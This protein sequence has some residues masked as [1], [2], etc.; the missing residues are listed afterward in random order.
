MNLQTLLYP[1]LFLLL[2]AP[3]CRETSA[4]KEYSGGSATSFDFSLNAFGRISANIHDSDK[5]LKFNRGNGVFRA[6]FSND[7]ESPFRGLGPLFNAASCNGC[8]FLNG[9]GR[10]KFP[11]E[12]RF[13]SLVFKFSMGKDQNNPYG[14]QLQDSSIDSKIPAEV[15][16]SVRF[17]EIKGKF[18]D[19][20]EYVL[21]KPDYQFMEWQYGK[22]EQFQYSPRTAPA[23]YGMGLLSLIPVETLKSLSDPEDKNKDGISGRINFVVNKKTGKEEI[24]RFGWKAGISSV[25][26]FIATA[27][28]E[29]MGV[30][31]FLFPSQN[32]EKGQVQCRNAQNEGPEIDSKTFDELEYYTLL[33]AVPARRNTEDRDVQSGE[34]LF[35]EIGCAGCHIAELKTGESPDLPELSKQIITPYTDLLLHDMGEELADGKNEFH[36][37]GKEWRTPPLW[38]L[39][40]V[41]LVN[42]HS[43]FLHDGRA[44]GF[45]EAILWH[46]GEAH[47]SKEKYKNLDKKDREKIIKFLN[48][49]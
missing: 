17:I 37:D 30:T 23:V 25:G 48:N 47:R 43:Q 22:P 21:H 8:H 26:Q 5:I 29:D 27:L 44:N 7:S 20:E 15:K 39:G 38:G 19:G 45:Q 36:A 3:G 4:G 13:H 11:Y 31:S 41:P 14:N 10:N 40:L 28:R 6:V 32:C 2:L 24:G 9:R 49:L 34:K 35:V 18:P 33:L 16:P 42:Q 46:D 12:T 1:V